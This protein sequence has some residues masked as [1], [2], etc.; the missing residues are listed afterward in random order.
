MTRGLSAPVIAVV[1]ASLACA[2]PASAYVARGGAGYRS[3]TVNTT[4]TRTTVTG[5]SVTR[6]TS[7]SGTSAGRVGTVAA[8][9]YGYHA[10]YVDR[11]VPVYGAP[12]AHYDAWGHPVAGAVAVTAT[13][14]AVGTVVASLPHT[15]CSAVSAGGVTY[16]NC[17]GTY[18]QPVYRGT[19]VQYV[20]VNPP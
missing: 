2:A 10:G 5:Q 15:G 3:G 6:S 11:S 14:V 1:A 17:S 16:E 9:A 4:A 19:S 13:A 8:P 20:V 18:Y 7:A 12:V